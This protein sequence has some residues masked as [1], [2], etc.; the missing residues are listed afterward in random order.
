[1]FMFVFFTVTPAGSYGYFI[2][3]SP[4]IA[5][6][7]V[8]LMIVKDVHILDITIITFLSLTP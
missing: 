3:L 8:A 7:T 1:M 2:D 5:L 4:D 6:I